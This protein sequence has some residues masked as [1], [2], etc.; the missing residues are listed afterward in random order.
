MPTQKPLR[1]LIPDI[2]QHIDQHK[3]L[4]QFN[5][6]LY[7][8]S[9]GQVK[10]FVE[11]SLRKEL[12]SSA[13]FNRAR[14]RIPSINVMRKAADKLSKV[15]LDA[16]MRLTNNKTDESI[17]TTIVRESNLNRV[18][19]DANRLYN[20]HNMFAIEPYVQDGNHKF[21]V[22]GGH[23]FLPY[24][25]DPINPMNMTVMIKLLGTDVDEFVPEYDDKG[26]LLERKD[27]DE[28]N[29]FALYTDKEFLIIDSK[30]GIRADKMSEFNLPDT[31]DFG[32]IPFIYKSKAR[33]QLIPFPN[34]EGFDISVLV[35]KLLTDLN[36][37]AQFMSHSIIWTKNA[38]LSGQ[39]INPDAIV[40]L[41]DS[42]QEDGDPDIGTIDPKVDIPN[43][44]ALIEYEMTNYFNSIG[45]KT[46]T[47]GVLDN[48]RDTSAVGKAIDE[49]D[50]TAERK[51]QTEMFRETENE[52]WS[53]VSAVQDVWSADNVVEESRK[54]SSAFED[55]FRIKYAEARPFKTEKQILEEI[56]LWRELKMMSRKQ[57]LRTLRPDFT[58]DQLNE[59]ISELDDEA[60]ENMERMLEGLPTL[61]AERNSD[62][63][64]N[65]GNEAAAE[66]DL[67]E[68]VN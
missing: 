66:P 4:L 47:K 20:I 36:Y 32:Q 23:Q 43:I 65:E 9:E 52:L 8:L 63:T 44:I 25:D 16:P 62:G 10:Q 26:N 51:V 58:E 7:E 27:I 18:M 21:R 46:N 17:M 45:I 6:K 41:G 12:I 64:F 55:T 50:A 19:Q 2:V 34:Q 14:Q 5:L 37:S 30:G 1:E 15:Y 33:L 31:H 3:E 13:A 67:E 56:Q 42:S 24:S 54:F 59:W 40:D 48:G 68:S 38:D 29:M 39:E 28:V 35:P 57:A 61:E 60:K 22:L 11:E 53:L 49:G